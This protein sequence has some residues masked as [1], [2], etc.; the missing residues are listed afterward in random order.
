MDSSISRDEHDLDFEKSRAI[1][2]K[3]TQ[4]TVETPNGMNVSTVIINTSSVYLNLLHR[5]EN[6]SHD[7]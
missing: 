1:L 3:G 7:H 4:L 5:I 6:L 2:A